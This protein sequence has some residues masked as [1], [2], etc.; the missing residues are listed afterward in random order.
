MKK[1]MTLFM[2]LG[3]LAGIVMLSVLTP[4]DTAEAIPAFARKYSMSCTTCHAP[5]PRL[6]EYGDEFAGNGFVLKDQE[7]PRYFMKTGDDNLDLIRDLPLAVRIDGFIQHQTV[8]DRDVDLSLPFNLKLLSGGSLTKDIAYYFY[9]YISERGEVVG[10]EDAYIMFNN[11]F[12]SELDIYLGQFQVSDPLFKRELRLT[13]EDYQ[14]YKFNPGNSRINMAY[15]RG[16]MMTYGFETGTDL[17]FE[18]INGNGIGVAD[19]EFKVY[20][21]DKYKCAVGRLSQNINDNL[22]LGVIGYYGKEGNQFVNEVT[23]GGIDATL[24]LG[25][26]ELNLQFLE[27]KDTDPFMEEDG[28]PDTKT[29]SRGGLAEL[30]IMPR[31]DRSKFYGVAS[32]NVVD[33]DHDTPGYHSITGHL[34]HVIRTNIRG[35][36]ENT[37]MIEDEENRFVLGIMVGF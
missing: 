5:V 32:Y 4:T 37:Y 28:R 15:D 30:I 2:I 21:N 26:A 22:R 14:I 3:P 25:A 23:M 11:V 12:N 7:A 8:S 20:D 13:Y 27:R 1:S 31:G 36:V 16:I 10:I 34:G 6:K 35:F 33:Y 18:I 24:A 29:L 19:E 9:F 17:I